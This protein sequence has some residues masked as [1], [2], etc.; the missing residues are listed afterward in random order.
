MINKDIVMLVIASRSYHYDLLINKYWSYL[1]KYIKENN[2]SIKIYLLFGNNVKHDDLNLNDD[3][4]LILN[5]PEC[6]IPGILIKTI[7]SFKIINNLYDYKHIIRTNLSSFFI[8]ENMLKISANLNDNNIYVGVNGTHKHHNKKIF[9]ISGAGFW[10]SR[11]NINYILNNENNLN[12]NLI[13]DVS[14]G[15]L[16]TNFNKSKL[17][18]YNLTNGIEI[19]DKKK[20]LEDIIKKEHY[21]IRIKSNN[22]HLDINYMNSFTEILYKK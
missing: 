6:K 13:D 5:T 17:I 21:H 22:K 10:L 3:D 19:S 16:L 20:L 1:I 9:F 7:E 4:K 12:I 8:V 15:C 11:D 14:I 18:R 2:Y